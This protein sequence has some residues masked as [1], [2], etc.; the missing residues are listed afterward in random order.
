MIA[1]EVVDAQLKAFN[2]EN[3][4]SR[5][6]IGASEL[7]YCGRKIYFRRILNKPPTWNSYM[8][9]G[10]IWHHA[11]REWLPYV[12]HKDYNYHYEVEGR[13]SDIVECHADAMFIEVQ[14]PHDV[15]TVIEYK[16]TRS[17]DTTPTP[18]YIAQANL[19]AFILDAQ[20]F[21]I[22]V[23]NVNDLANA[24]VTRFTTSEAFAD[25]FINKACHLRTRILDKAPPTKDC[26]VKEW[27]CQYCDYAKECQE[28]S[29]Q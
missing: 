24:S 8:V 2:K 23:Q 19:T 15:A 14:T 29:T 18:A 16:T 20:Y 22:I 1:P 27:E 3:L 12:L 6:I 25:Y 28:V 10:S 9:Q 21:I 7:P 4:E 5:T 17:K 11:L 13:Y 26:P